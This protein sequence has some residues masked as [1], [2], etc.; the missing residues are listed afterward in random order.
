MHRQKSYKKDKKK[1][2]ISDKERALERERQHKL[3]VR[4]M[5][6]N[7]RVAILGFKLIN[8]SDALSR[9]IFVNR[10]VNNE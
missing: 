5:K 8:E 2:R 3:T 10:G 9:L 1:I 4:A 7:Y 6:R